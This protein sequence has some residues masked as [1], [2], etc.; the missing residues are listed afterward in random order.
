MKS[1]FFCKTL[2]R[3]NAYL[4]MILF[5]LLFKMIYVKIVFLYDKKKEKKMKVWNFYGRKKE[6]KK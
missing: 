4:N 6:G 1:F 2:K 5:E 3:I